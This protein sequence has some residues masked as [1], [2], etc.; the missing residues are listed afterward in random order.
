MNQIYSTLEYIWKR[1]HCGES[2]DIESDIIGL[3]SRQNIKIRQIDGDLTQ[4]N[5]SIPITIKNA[6]VI[7][8]RYIKKDGTCTEDHFLCE[9]YVV[10]ST[11]QLE[12][13]PHY[14]ARLE[15]R[16]HEYHGT[17]NSKSILFNQMPKTAS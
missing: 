11:M 3:L 6:F 8:L 1:A 15:F 4:I 13:E 7:G 10:S 17:H 14:K 5:I 16:L 12:I 2:V 9:K